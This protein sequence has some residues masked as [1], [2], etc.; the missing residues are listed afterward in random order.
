MDGLGFFN[1]R[2]IIQVLGFVRKLI[3]SIRI[4][5]RH[6]THFVHAATVGATDMAEIKPTRQPEVKLV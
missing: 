5:S 3:F 1:I 6:C 4:C 2:D